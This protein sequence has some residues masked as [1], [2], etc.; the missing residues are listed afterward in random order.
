M[1]FQP[2]GG[3]QM[4]VLG[5]ALCFQGLDWV[6]GRWDSNSPLGEQRMQCRPRLERLWIYRKRWSIREL[7][8]A[9]QVGSALRLCV[10]RS[11]EMTPGIEGLSESYRLEWAKLHS[12]INMLSTTLCHRPEAAARNRGSCSVT[13]RLYGLDTTLRFL[14][15]Y[16][17]K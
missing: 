8:W 15:V 13:Y 2:N 17:I 16:I 12:H 9:V 3:P 7:S 5:A 6:M 1:E 4:A 14:R 10:K 11:R